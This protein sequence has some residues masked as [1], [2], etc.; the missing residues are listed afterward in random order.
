KEHALAVVSAINKDLQTDE[1]FADA[2][3][4]EKWCGDVEKK[5]DAAKEHALAQTQSIDELFRTTDD[6]RE[7]FRRTRLDLDKLVKARKEAIRGEILQG[8]KGKY[9]AHL[10]ALNDSLGTPLLLNDRTGAVPAA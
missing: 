7:Q 3:Q 4:T 8:G 1:D 5:L 2:E 10:E 6:I 9:A